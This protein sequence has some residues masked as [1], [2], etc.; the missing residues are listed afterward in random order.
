[1]VNFCAIVGCANRAGRDKDKSFYRLPAIIKNQGAQTEQLS[2]RRL[3][4][5][6]ASGNSSKRS[7]SGKLPL[8]MI[9]VC[10]D[11]FTSG[12]PAKLYD[13][14]NPDWAPSLNLWHCEAKTGDSLSRHD[15]ATKRRKLNEEQAIAKEERDKQEQRI[16]EEEKRLRCEVQKSRCELDEVK[17]ELARTHEK[18]CANTLDEE[19]FRDNDEKVFFFFHRYTKVG[20][21]SGAA[22]ILEAS[23]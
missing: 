4:A 20:S 14:T 18:L 1:M 6:L 5:E 12:K 8:H 16:R 13:T 15:R 22:Y 3:S 17:K 10:S 19:S 9:R 21:S 23:A 7:Q 2:E 11:H